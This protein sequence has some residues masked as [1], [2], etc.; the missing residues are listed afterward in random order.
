MSANSIALGDGDPALGYGAQ[1]ESPFPHTTPE[2]CALPAFGATSAYDLTIVVQARSGAR[3]VACWS[4]ASGP[5]LLHRPSQRTVMSLA[6]KV[7]ALFPHVQLRKP[8]RGSNSLYEVSARCLDPYLLLPSSSRMPLALP[9]PRRPSNPMNQQYCE[10]ARR[11]GPARAALLFLPGEEPLLRKAGYLWSRKNSAHQ[12]GPPSEPFDYLA[13]C[14]LFWM[15]HAR[16]WL[17]GR[18]SSLL[19][20]IH[21]HD[22]G[23]I[24]RTADS[25]V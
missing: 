10:T 19:C 23:R 11:R 25:N 4:A 3:I 15:R 14:Y 1:P 9:F 16:N 2:T 7:D 17:R 6:D 21:W 24:S 20:G 13:Y 22:R 8:V 18:D 5:W 12:N